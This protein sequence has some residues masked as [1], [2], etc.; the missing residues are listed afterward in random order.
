MYRLV[1]N[2]KRLKK[3][4][5]RLSWS[6]GNLFE[7]VNS[8]R[9]NLR[10]VQDICDKE[11]CNAEIRKEAAKVLNEYVEAKSEGNRYEGEGVAAQFVAHFENFLGKT[12]PVEPL[13][14]G[15]FKNVLNTEEAN[16]MVRCVTDEEIKEAMFEI[17]SNKA[18]G[19]DGYTSGFFKK[20][21]VVIGKDVCN[22]VREFFI[23]GK[24]L[25]EVNA[26]L[27]ALI[28]NITTP[29]KVSDFRPIACCNVIYKCISK[30]LTKR[31]QNVLGKIVH[32][33]Q[34]SFV[35]GRHI[36]DNIL[37]AQELLRG[38]NRKYGPRRCAMQIDIQK[39]Y[40]T[41]LRNS[42]IILGVRCCA[43]DLLVLCKG[44][45]ASVKVVKQS[46]DDFSKVS[47][48]IPNLG[49]SVIF[50]GSMAERDKAEILQIM[51]FK[52][53][54]LPV[55]YLGV[56]LLAKKLSVADCRILID[57]I[58]SRIDCWRNKTL[59]YAGR[60]Q[61]ISSVLASMQVYWASVYMIPNTVIKELRK[62]SKVFY[63]ILG[64]LLKFWKIVEDKDSLWAKW[65]NVVKLKNSNVWVVSVDKQDSWGWK[66][67]MDLRDKIRGFVRY[68]VGNGRRISL[69][70][71]R[72]CTVGPL[73]D[74]ITRRT[75]FE[76][77]FRDNMTVANMI[78][79]GKWR[80][81]ED[82][83]NKYE[84][85]RDIEFCTNQVW[86]DLRPDWEKVVWKNVVWF[87]HM[88]PRH[89][90]IL[91]LAV[92]RKLMTQDRIMKWQTN[93]D[94]T[95][96]LCQRG[97]DSHEHLFFQCEY[98]MQVWKNITDNSPILSGSIGMFDVIE[99]IAAMKTQN[100]LA[101][102]V[103]KLVLAASVYFVWQERNL[104][105]F[106][107][108]ERSV[109]TL[110]RIIKDNVRHKMMSISVKNTMKVSN[111]AKGW[112][113]RWSNNSLVAIED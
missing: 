57:R 12:L 14:E 92:Q 78:I 1:Q 47:G 104:R 44:D 31:I 40:D 84:F 22:A 61:L 2:L 24:L 33:I 76:G 86:K 15:L 106:K 79:D 34:S 21:W 60:I 18:S 9:E 23:N 68:E 55:R 41:I 110:C 32:I 39:A 87:S 95:C 77:K 28:P 66:V 88:V 98:A 17:D 37:I 85:L 96:P 73:C 89:A 25:G 54:K 52:C 74:Q 42:S 70:Y 7:K 6:N 112:N 81:P 30:I 67:M 94:F 46:L 65:V 108:E 113:L 11:P 53:G 51:P 102:I 63:G 50:F 19:P 91:W 56:P 20:A 26:T 64:N 105:N 16:E 5:N 107:K 82:W 38:Y 99:K 13:M 43:D 90:F 49:K 72:W 35:L 93:G 27:V 29:N 69:W 80:W 97:V 62:F 109:E 4:L 103:S 36:Q 58:K 45:V 83:L 111:I 59:S 10:K 8:L 3:P 100:N 48:L 101:V 75:I 71:D